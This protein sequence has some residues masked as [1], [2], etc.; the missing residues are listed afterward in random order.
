MTELIQE[1][2][3]ALNI[4]VKE[5]KI[6]ALQKQLNEIVEERNDKIQ[7]ETERLKAECQLQIDDIEKQLKAL[8]E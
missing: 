1:Q 7:V 3:D 6:K 8:E 2:L 4:I 5:Q